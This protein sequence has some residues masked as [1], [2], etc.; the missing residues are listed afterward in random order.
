MVQVEIEQMNHERATYFPTSQSTMFGFRVLFL[1]LFCF[2][3]FV[4]VFFICFFFNVKTVAYLDAATF[5]YIKGELH[6]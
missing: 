4:F 6:P 5:I 2:V 3:F 1:F